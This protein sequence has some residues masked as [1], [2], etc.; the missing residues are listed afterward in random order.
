MLL[1][2]MTY[3][4]AGDFKPSLARILIAAI[5]LGAL[6]NAAAPAVLSTEQT[7]GLPDVG[8]SKVVL[9]CAALGL[10]RLL[11]APRLGELL[12]FML[13][14]AIGALLRS[15]DAAWLGLSISMF[16]LLSAKRTTGR[17]RDG[18]AILLAV[19][20][21]APIV[22][23]AGL[24]IGG[25]LLALDT[26]LAAALLSLSGTPVSASAASLSVAGGMDL[27]LVWR[28]GVLGNLS[29]ALMMWYTA[30]RFVLGGLP[31]RTLSAAVLVAAVMIAVNALRIAGMA[32]DAETYEWL[33][34][35]RGASLVRLAALG[36]VGGI[37]AF[38]LRRLS[39]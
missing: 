37:I 13:P 21:H 31:V 9:C 16:L 25:D 1:C 5:V 33:H 15:A 38:D 14:T 30:T 35:G 10:Y 17:A 28:C 27:L 32:L 8:V 3:G 39:A 24:L 11:Q 20:L 4:S 6:V 2:V 18:A 23:V 36:F 7:G 26:K 34:D 22:S 12:P 29:V 19:G